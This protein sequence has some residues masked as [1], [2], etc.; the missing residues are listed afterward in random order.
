[1]KWNNFN[2]HW[3]QVEKD[4]VVSQILHKP[5]R[6]VM[7]IS[8]SVQIYQ[9]LLGSKDTLQFHQNV[10][11]GK[12]SFQFDDDEPQEILGINNYGAFLL[13]LQQQVVDNK[14][15]KNSAL[16]EFTSKEGKKMKLFIKDED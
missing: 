13:K 2:K 8:P 16:V 9:D 11:T 6:E 3:F 1:M 4:V 14:L 7:K 12:L 10:L 15:V 5:A